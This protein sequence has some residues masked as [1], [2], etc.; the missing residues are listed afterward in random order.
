MSDGKLFMRRMEIVDEFD[1]VIYK[2]K[3]LPVR[4]AMQG[5]LEIIEYKDSKKTVVKIFSKSIKFLDKEFKT[6]FNMEDEK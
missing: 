1:N 6:L 2:V 5:A 4:Y 3:D